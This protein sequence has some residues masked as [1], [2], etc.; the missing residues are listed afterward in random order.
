MIQAN[1]TKEEYEEKEDGEVK[2]GGKAKEAMTEAN[3]AT[4]SEQIEKEELEI[5]LV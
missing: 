5:R 3:T 2:K 4:G 1:D